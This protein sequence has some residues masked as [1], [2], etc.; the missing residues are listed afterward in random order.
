[1]SDVVPVPVPVRGGGG[2]TLAI[3]WPWAWKRKRG[4][5][6]ARGERG[7]V[8]GR[9]A[10]GFRGRGMGLWLT[11]SVAGKRKSEIRKRKRRLASKAASG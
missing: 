5:E 7:A 8:P 10:G 1:M 6:D 11:K 3:A 9:A 4:A 2:G